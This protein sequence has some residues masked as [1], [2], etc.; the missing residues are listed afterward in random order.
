MAG[1]LIHLIA[2]VISAVIAYFIFKK[3]DYIAAIFIGNFIPDIIAFGYASIMSWSLNPYTVLQSPAWTLDNFYVTQSFWIFFQALF[4][5]SFLLFHVYVK[6]K[7]PNY[8]MEG[9]L[10][11][12]LFGF[13]IHMM[14]DMFILEHGIW[15]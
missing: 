5:T 14:M 8:E 6:K 2:A 10:A 4:I 15:Y 3:R 12:F 1:L 11:L 9:I 7:K 13:L